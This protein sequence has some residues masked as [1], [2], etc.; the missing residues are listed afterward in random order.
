VSVVGIGV[1]VRV[2]EGDG[3]G[4]GVGKPSPASITTLSEAVTVGGSSAAFVPVN[5]AVV[6]KAPLAASVSVTTYSA[7][8]VSVTLAPT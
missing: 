8:Q 5:V 4:V 2:G 3:V 1:G 7:R 6:E